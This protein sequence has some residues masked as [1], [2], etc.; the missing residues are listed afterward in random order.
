MPVSVARGGA[1]GVTEEQKGGPGVRQISAVF[2]L[3]D[4]QPQRPVAYSN[5]HRSAVSRA[6][7]APNG[8]PHSGR[9]PMA[10]IW[11]LGTSWS[12]LVLFS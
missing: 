6:G 11:K 4:E 9:H 10:H 1:Q 8:S 5:T 2:M 12:I 7:F 3:H